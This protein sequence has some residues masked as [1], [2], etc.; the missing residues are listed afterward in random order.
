MGNPI[1]SS[2]GPSAVRC[3]LVKQ[4]SG[5]VKCEEVKRLQGRLVFASLTPRT[6]PPAK[7]QTSEGPAGNF[8]FK[9]AL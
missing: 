9:P 7:N 1:L 8:V 4:C 5:A 6:D 2:S 3:I